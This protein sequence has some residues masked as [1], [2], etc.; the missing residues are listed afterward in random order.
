[1]NSGRADC[2]HHT[3]SEGTTVSSAGRI[4]LDEVIALVTDVRDVQWPA[5]E[6]AWVRDC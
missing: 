4:Y 1:M 2:T 6:R 3:T 5:I